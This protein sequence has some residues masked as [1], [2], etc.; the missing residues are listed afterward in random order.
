[1]EEDINDLIKSIGEKGLQLLSSY[2][3]NSPQL[4]QYI[5]NFFSIATDF[6]G[7]F[8]NI[9]MNP[10]KF[11]P[12]QVNYW[13]ES[14][15][16]LQDQFNYW[17][18]G[19]KF[20]P[21]NDKRFQNQEWENNP[22]FNL[23]G[24]HY[25]LAYKHINSLLREIDSEDAQLAKRVKFFTR[26]F[27]DALSPNNYIYTNP[28]LL[29]ETVKS[30]GE[31][32]LKGFNNFLSDINEQPSNFTIKMSDEKAFEIGKN[33][34]TTAGKVIFKNDLMEL[35]QYA[36]QT[37]KVRE[38]PLLVIP[39]WINKFYILDLSPNNSLI[40]WLV[41]QGIT[42]FAIS[43]VNPDSKLAKKSLWNYLKEG[44]L[45][46]L[47]VIR[48]QLNVKTVNT[49]GFCIGGTLQAMLL[50]YLKAK[51]KKLINSST[52]L[53]SMI[54]FSNPGEISVFIDEKQIVALEKQM[55]EKGFFDGQAMAHAFNSL[56]A[57]DLIWSFF[58][59]NYLLGK[60]P[61]P[62]DILY[63]NSDTTNMP[64]QMHSQ[65]LRWM[66]LQNDLIKPNKI[67]LNNTPLDVTKIDTPSI[68]ISTQ[69]DHIAPWQTT[70][71]G[72]QVFKG[73]K[74]FIL[75]G[76]G[77]IAGIINPPENKKYEFFVHSQ[78]ESCAEEW[79]AKAN[80]HSGSWW[81]TWLT[82]LYDHSGREVPA[83]QWKVLP[84]KSLGKAPGKYVYKKST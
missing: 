12:M 37:K 32:L 84:Y 60:S 7:F 11:W 3:K 59:K 45:T 71:V 73:E 50:A 75:G 2:P 35:I 44:P 14:N 22:F 83:P 55:N 49:L 80:K 4:P 36:P 28:E 46:A 64:A 82:W 77:H 1:M 38:I 21:L 52:F 31:N 10:D 16:L 51:N 5:E 19:K 33:I 68:F 66:Y 41:K 8:S 9:L 15:R 23:L 26:Q 34:A 79:I 30:K 40:G 65:Y 72:Y 57:T 76:S 67:K 61:V 47:Q 20:H 18:E 43:W 27:L 81:P 70:Y 17:K 56:R 58:I 42:V 6:H 24:Q 63:W 13:E 78:E 74:Q 54:D 69:K 53:A 48:K 39:P 29:S 25:L 62:F